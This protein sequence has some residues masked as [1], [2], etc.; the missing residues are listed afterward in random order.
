MILA[1]AGRRIDPAQTAVVRRF[2]LAAVAYVQRE[3]ERVLRHL[4]PSAVVGSAACGADLLV[5]EAAGRLRLR[6]HVVLPFDRATFR[7][8]SVADRPGDWGPQFD[9]VIAGVSAS[10][11]LLEMT[12][13]PHDPGTYQQAN[14]EILRQAEST[15]REASTHCHALVVWNGA[16]RGPGDVTQ[17]FLN[18]ARRRGWPTTEIDTATP[19]AIANPT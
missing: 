10:G 16:P 9:A 3:V 11:D 13:D 6:R 15:A 5:L 12:L 4:A 7:V 17:A 1:Y 2:P 14:V 18:E 19:D 8:T